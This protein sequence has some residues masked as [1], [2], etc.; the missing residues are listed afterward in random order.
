MFNADEFHKRFEAQIAWDV[1]FESREW[2]SKI[3]YMSL[4]SDV[5][6]KVI[7]P[8]AGAV[9]RFM[10]KKGNRTVSVYLDCYSILG[11]MNKPYWEIYP[12]KGDTYRCYIDEVD[13]LS[14]KITEE[15]NREQ[16]E[17]EDEHIWE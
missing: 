2:A 4:P 13:E 16:S 1:N 6:F 11:A 10:V 17:E 5:E 3:P 15:L 7:P 14:E 12:Y 9:A 8:F